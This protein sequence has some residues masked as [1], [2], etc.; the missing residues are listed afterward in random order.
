MADVS[1]GWGRLTWGQADWDDSTVYA[2]GWGAKSWNDGAW[3]EL[4]N[5]VLTLSGLE[6]SLGYIIGGAIRGLICGLG[7][8]IMCLFITDMKIINFPL[9]VF[10]LLT[11]LIDYLK[12]EK[13]EF[14]S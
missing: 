7:I 12:N 9:T 14:G 5:V 4:H 3:G 6:I 1:S 10:Y 2:I 8:L 11:V 13:N